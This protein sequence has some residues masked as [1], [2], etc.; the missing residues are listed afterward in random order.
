MD[1][2]HSVRRNSAY[3]LLT[4]LAIRWVPSLGMEL[5]CTSS[6]TAAWPVAA[7]WL[8]RAAAISRLDIAVNYSADCLGRACN[9]GYTHNLSL[10]A[11]A[12]RTSTFRS[13]CTKGTRPDRHNA[14]G[15]LAYMCYITIAR[16]DYILKDEFPSQWATT[17][18]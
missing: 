17:S 7:T 3:G 14:A 15:Y 12:T 4:D 13:G 11:R 6:A 8:R 2:A 1:K 16:A 18:V 5:P 10:V 9:D